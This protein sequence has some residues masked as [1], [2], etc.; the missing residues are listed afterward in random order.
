VSDN[1]PNTPAEMDAD[2]R[3]DVLGLR[4]AIWV[5]VFLGVVHSI[6]V[7]K[8]ALLS[9][10]TVAV[11]GVMVILAVAIYAAIVALLPARPAK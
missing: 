8:Y 1:N 11:I 3:K 5:G 7:F 10:Y 9:M 4:I 6:F 2:E